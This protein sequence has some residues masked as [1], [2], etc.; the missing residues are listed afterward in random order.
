MTVKKKT[1]QTVTVFPYTLIIVNWS[2]REVE[3]EV[4][5]EL[6]TYNGRRIKQLHIEIIPN[7]A[8]VYFKNDKYKETSFPH[9]E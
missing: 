6:E 8:A 7:N 1:I 4:L 2:N 9:R 3:L 5:P